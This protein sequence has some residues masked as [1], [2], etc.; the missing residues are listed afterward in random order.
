MEQIITRSL[1]PYFSGLNSTIR[2]VKNVQTLYEPINAFRFNLF[3]FWYPGENKLSQIIAFFLDPKQTHGQGDVFL[4]IFLDQ[5]GLG[6]FVSDTT[7]VTV[8]CE[9]AITNQRRI[10]IL[11]SFY[12]DR[13]AVAIEN[14]FGADDQENQLYDYAKYLKSKFNKHV[15]FYL[16]P[17]GHKPSLT[18]ISKESYDLYI[19]EGSMQTISYT[20]NIINLINQ[21]SLVCR[22]DRVRFFLNDFEQYFKQELIGDTFMN[23][24]QI[25]ADYALSTSENLAVAFETFKAFNTI[26]DEVGKLFTERLTQK[27]QN[28]FK[29]DA[30]S[31][32]PYGNL[33]IVIARTTWP[34]NIFVGI[35]D[36]D[37]DRVHFNIKMEN[38]DSQALYSYVKNEIG[39]SFNNNCWWLRLVPIYNRWDEKLE[40]ITALYNLSEEALNYMVDGVIQ[41]ADIVDRFSSTSC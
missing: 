18:S 7:N 14:K 33:N 40:G 1:K 8:K 11:I 35:R 2:T 39:G 41:I 29:E 32:I 5:F 10:D 37:N 3:N 20:N 15:L 34:D 31:V 16:T 23:E 22:A 25:V 17:K 26:K 13:F 38:V 36:F 24:H 9:Y 6:Q 28:I 4:K 19:S 21:W 27:L 12:N 30:W